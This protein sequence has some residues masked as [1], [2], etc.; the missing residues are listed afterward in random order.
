[1]VMPNFLIIGAAKSGTSALYH[2]IRRHPEIYMSPRKETHFFAFENSNPATS[3]PG[4]TI[5]G[6][7]THLDEYKK[8]FENVR[9]EKII[10]EASPTY[11]YLPKACNRIKFHI[12]DVRMVAILRN[13][14]DRAYSAYMHLIRDGRESIS[15]FDQALKKEQERIAANWGP[16]WHYKRGGLY[17]EQV[18][19]YYESFDKD[20]LRIFLYEDLD[21]NPHKVLK[22]LFNY[23]GVSDL[24]MPDV[25]VRPNVSGVPKSTHLHTLMHTLFLKPNLLKSVS[26]KVIP[27]QIRWRVTTQMRTMNMAKRPMAPDVRTRLKEFFREDVQ[28]LSQ[29]IGRNLSHWLE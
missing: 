18:K 27:E 5:P 10:G 8:L 22:D 12:P 9:D 28:N 23:L 25:S 24:W 2:Y 20:R 6:A 13:P 14:V 7:I 15:D 19:R 1:M 4:D 29:L 21:S 17:Y 11:I 3:G 26:R 16:I